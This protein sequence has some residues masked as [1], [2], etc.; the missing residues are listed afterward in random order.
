MQNT[1]FEI[2]NQN[3]YIDLA[4][5]SCLLISTII[6]DTP[7]AQKVFSNEQVIERLIF[8]ADF[9]Q[10]IN[11]SDPEAS[12]ESLQKISF[13]AFLALVGILKSNPAAQ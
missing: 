8:L 1:I 11:E 2:I 10:L 9:N 12:L 4:G 5:Q 3:Q 13:F 6:K 7:S